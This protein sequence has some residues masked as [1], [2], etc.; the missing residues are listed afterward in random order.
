MP[1]TK[2]SLE[3]AQNFLREFEDA[4]RSYYRN[5]EN[6]LKLVNERTNTKSHGFYVQ[7][8]K[9]VK[10]YINPY[11]FSN[12]WI[13]SLF[14]DEQSKKPENKRRYFDNTYLGYFENLIDFYQD[15]IF[16]GYDEDNQPIFENK[17]VL[18]KETDSRTIPVL[19]RTNPI[20][21]KKILVLGCILLLF[22]IPNTE[23]N[24]KNLEWTK[25]V[26][27]CYDTDLKDTRRDRINIVAFAESETKNNSRF[28]KKLYD[29]LQKINIRD[30][31]GYAI[32]YCEGYS[33]YRN[34]QETRKD[35]I[36][37][38]SYVQT[39]MT[40]SIEYFSKDGKVASVNNNS[41]VYDLNLDKFNRIDGRIW[42]PNE[43]DAHST[44]ILAYILMIKHLSTYKYNTYRM[45]KAIQYINSFL[46]KNQDSSKNVDMI[47][48]RAFLFKRM[49]SIEAYIRDMTLALEYQPNDGEALRS[50]SNHYKIGN[51]SKG[52]KYFEK[53]IKLNS[54][55]SHLK[56]EYFLYKAKVN[57]D[58]K[59]LLNELDSLAPTGNTSMLNQIRGIALLNL[60][61]KQEG[62]LCFKKLAENGGKPA[63]LN[64]AYANYVSNNFEESKQILQEL[65]NVESKNTN[66]IFIQNL[67]KALASCHY[68]LG[69]YQK[70]IDLFKENDSY[71]AVGYIY[72]IDGNYQKALDNTSRFIS[73]NPSDP[74]GYNQRRVIA[75]KM[76]K[77]S[78]ASQ[79]SLLIINSLDKG[80]FVEQKHIK[81]FKQIGIEKVLA[82]VGYNFKSHP[83]PIY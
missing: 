7:A 50:L 72:Y 82:D 8:S 1:S 58:F 31:L 40:V 37:V 19:I 77:Y 67:N 59:T 46:V 23:V 4:Y 39:G 52:L 69:D 13:W 74:D 22:F 41:L 65:K 60:G 15:N 48:Y 57:N 32:Q 61:R 28:A 73:Y 54:V 81:K 38:S 11:G 9:D 68:R 76:K 3:E 51:D 62:L 30:S 26:I 70:A 47:T 42:V 83:R 33:Q 27:P 36:D 44:D 14:I 29:K 16:M 21:T 45:E 34:F 43:F 35:S 20:N 80:Y 78:I 79:D 18:K 5:S 17:N 55:S 63:K 2:V 56:M 10:A 25:D 75:N 71:L 6:L 66:S 49:D 64:Y 53:R 12:S 24:P